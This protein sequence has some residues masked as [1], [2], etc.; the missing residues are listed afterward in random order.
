MALMVA[1]SDSKGTRSEL[2]F[3]SMSPAVVGKAA[4]AIGPSLRTAHAKLLRVP[5]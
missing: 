3:F 2:T 5:K 1:A 4:K